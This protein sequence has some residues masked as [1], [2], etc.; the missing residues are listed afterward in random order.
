MDT[1]YEKG[2]DK[3]GF[4][5]YYTKQKLKILYIGRESRDLKPE[6]DYSDYIKYIYNCYTGKEKEISEKPINRHAFHRRLLKISY[7]LINEKEWVD[8][9]KASEIAESFGTKNGISFAFTNLSKISNCDDDSTKIN[10][11]FKG[12]VKN[13]KHYLKEEISILKPDLIIGMNMINWKGFSA[14]DICATKAYDDDKNIYKVKIDDLRT[15]YIDSYH[16]SARY[17][18]DERDFFDLI[19]NCLAKIKR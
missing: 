10:G 18:K 14:E 5:P 19:R 13:T 16:F 4:Y 3:Y 11:N 12:N 1:L 6:S 15:S 17:K 8:I 9:P 2:Y 7:G